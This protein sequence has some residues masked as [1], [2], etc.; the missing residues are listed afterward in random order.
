MKLSTIAFLTAVLF[1][2]AVGLAKQSTPRSDDIQIELAQ[3]NEFV[4]KLMDV[5]DNSGKKI[6]NLV[7]LDSFSYEKKVFGFKNSKGKIQSIPDIKIKKIV[8]SRL[9]QGVLTGKPE[10]LRVNVW[11]GKIKKIELNYRAVKIK[12]GYLFWGQDEVLTHFA[13]SDTL[14]ADSS[15]WGEKLSNFWQRQK[16]ESPKIFASNFGFK[17]GYGIMSRKMAAAY[18]QACLKIEILSLTIDPKKNTIL[19]HCKDVFYDKYNE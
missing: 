17:D 1:M 2:P 18:C 6:K 16:E 7:E 15:E 11:N 4:V 5:F 19:I 12:D 8:F 10:S 9:R 3:E 14:R 13:G